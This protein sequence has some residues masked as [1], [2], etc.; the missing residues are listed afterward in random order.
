[1]GLDQ[2]IPWSE[3]LLRENGDGATIYMQVKCSKHLHVVRPEIS[4]L[5]SKS[6]LSLSTI[7]AKLL[8]LELYL[9]WVL[10]IVLIQGN[11]V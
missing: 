3:V 1:M 9:H 11:C 6:S 10:V 4:H 7:R 2:F 8:V 5:T